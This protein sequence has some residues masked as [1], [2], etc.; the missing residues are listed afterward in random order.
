MGDMWDFDPNRRSNNYAFATYCPR[1]TPSF[2]AHAHRSHALSAITNQKQGILYEHTGTMWKE[3]LRITSWKDALK[4]KCENCNKDLI[5]TI[6][7][8]YQGGSPYRVRRGSVVWI[9]DASGL[10]LE[11]LCEECN[12]NKK[13]RARNSVEWGDGE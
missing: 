6:P 7:S 12:R 3:V 5:V 8:K 11:C 2:K 10:H 1:R 13:H 4:D 9:D